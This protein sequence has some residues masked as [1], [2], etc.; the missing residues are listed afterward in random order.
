MSA[1]QIRPGET[2]ASVQAKFHYSM[3]V[4]PFHNLIVCLRQQNGG[5]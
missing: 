2:L 4:V 1:P 5:V 3:V